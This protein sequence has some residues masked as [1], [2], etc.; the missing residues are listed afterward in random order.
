MT[1]K[2]ARFSD[3]TALYCVV[4]LEDESLEHSATNSLHTGEGGQRSFYIRAVNIIN[5]KQPQPHPGVQQVGCTLLGN[6]FI[7]I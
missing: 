7:F 2:N 3:C 5:Q 6:F 1:I 4:Q